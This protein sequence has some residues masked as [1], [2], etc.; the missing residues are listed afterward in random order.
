MPCQKRP[1]L[2]MWREV[3]SAALGCGVSQLSPR[4]IRANCTAICFSDVIDVPH[5]EK[6][7]CLLNTAFAFCRCWLLLRGARVSC[8]LKRN[9]V[10]APRTCTQQTCFFGIMIS[11]CCTYS[12]IVCTRRFV[13]KLATRAPRLRTTSTHINQAPP[14]WFSE[15]GRPVLFRRNGP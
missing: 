10:G 15:R 3:R 4:S 1:C 12:A 13:A 7:I 14:T 2:W 8:I 9:F 11:A 6:Q 5:D